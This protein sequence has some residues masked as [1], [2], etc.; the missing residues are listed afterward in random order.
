MVNDGQVGVDPLGRLFIQ[1]NID[2]FLLLFLVGHS[3]SFYVFKQKNPQPA[4]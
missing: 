4:G 1:F 3:L 2:L